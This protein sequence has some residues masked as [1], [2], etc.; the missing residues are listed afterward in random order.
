MRWERSTTGWVL[1]I[2]SALQV[3]LLFALGVAV[4]KT[5]ERPIALIVSGLAILWPASIGL[6]LRHRRWRIGAGLARPNLVEDA[7]VVLLSVGLAPLGTVI[8]LCPVLIGALG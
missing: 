4:S 3:I 2:A 6:A 5:P 8:V 7:F 1:L